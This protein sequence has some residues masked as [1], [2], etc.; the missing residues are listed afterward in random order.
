MQCPDTLGERSAAFGRACGCGRAIG[1]TVDR[2][3]RGFRCRGFCSQH[4][5]D[6]G[7]RPFQLHREFCDLSGDVVDALA[8]QCVFHALG[9]P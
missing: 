8:Q 5:L 2:L 7:I 6:R 3:G 1:R 9:R 4:G